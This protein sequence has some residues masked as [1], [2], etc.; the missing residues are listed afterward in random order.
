MYNNNNNN[1]NNNM[2]FSENGKANLI[3]NFLKKKTYFIYMLFSNL[4]LPYVLI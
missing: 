1:N 4:I 2:Q 3:V